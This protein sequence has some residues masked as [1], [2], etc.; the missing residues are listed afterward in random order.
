[1]ILLSSV[2]PHILLFDTY[3]HPVSLLLPPTLP[4]PIPPPSLLT[5]LPQTRNIQ[6]LLLPPP[7]GNLQY[8]PRLCLQAKFHNMLYHNVFHNRI[9]RLAMKVSIYY[10]PTSCISSYNLGYSQVPYFRHQ[11]FLPISSVQTC[12]GNPPA[13]SQCMFL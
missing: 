10:N 2:Q 6:S 9:K 13:S 8:Q 7:L 5:L 4:V 1:M 3:C 11:G 12:V